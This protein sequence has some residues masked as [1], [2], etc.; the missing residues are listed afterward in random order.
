MAAGMSCCGRSSRR[1]GRCSCQHA[2]KHHRTQKGRC[3]APGPET[4]SRD[5]HDGRHAAQR[6]VQGGG[7][8]AAS[9]WWGCALWRGGREVEPQTGCVRGGSDGTKKPSSSL[10]KR[11]VQ[12]RTR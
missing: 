11:T 6:G 5:P 2:R 9:G 12:N 8:G 1:R 4:F 7:W 10:E 3:I